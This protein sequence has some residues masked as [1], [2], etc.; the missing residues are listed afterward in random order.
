G[1]TS[2]DLMS[3]DWSPGSPTTATGSLLSLNVG[4]NGTLGN[5]FEI[6][7]NGSD[8][9]T[10]SQTGINSAV[11]HSFSAAGDVSIA[12]DIQFTNQTASTIKS[13]GPLTIESGESFESQNL[14]FK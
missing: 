9:F 7:D 12:Y 3:I 1:L 6:Q 13:D 4:A 10:V 5:I 2:G 14:T 8:I 11:P